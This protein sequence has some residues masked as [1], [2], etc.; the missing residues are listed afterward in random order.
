MKEL[1]RRGLEHVQDDLGV[2][3]V[4]T[5][6]EPKLVG[7]IDLDQIALKL[8]AQLGS[9]KVQRRLRKNQ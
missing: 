9:V 7:T 2:F 5:I 8:P 4:A 1:H 3:R 6:F